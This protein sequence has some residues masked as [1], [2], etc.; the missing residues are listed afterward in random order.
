M[1]VCGVWGDRDET[2]VSSLRGYLGPRHEIVKH[3]GSAGEELVASRT[4]W[5]AGLMSGWMWVLKRELCENGF[6]F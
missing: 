1:S 3:W 4:V 5:A 2:E 6:Q